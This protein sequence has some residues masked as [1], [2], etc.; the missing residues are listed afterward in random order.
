[1]SQDVTGRGIGQPGSFL[2]TITPS[3]TEELQYVTRAVRVGTGG[4]LAVKTDGGSVVTIPDVLSGETLAIRC[5]R[6]YATNTT[7]SGIV[8]IT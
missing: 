7:A 1:M 3:D 2:F 6:V 5:V 8:G 4:D